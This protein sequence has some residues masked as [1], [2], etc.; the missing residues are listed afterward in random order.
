[1]DRFEEIDAFVRII[2]SGG[3]SAAAARTGAAKSKLSRRLADLEARLGVQLV[4][5]TTRSWT[6]TD[7]GR[8]FYQRAVRLLSDLREAE[9]SATA[10]QAA[11]S[12]RLRIAAPLSFGVAHMGPMLTKFA[13]DHPKV[14]LDIEFNDRPTDLVEEGFD[15]AIRI[16]RLASSSLVARKLCNITVIA[17]GAP[18]FWERF[19][20]P[21]TAEEL[22][23]L[24][25]LRYANAPPVLRAAPPEAQDRAV[26][27]A[28]NGDF[29]TR[30]CV[31]GLGFLIAPTFLVHREIESGALEPVL[32]DHKWSDL[33][34][35][36]LYPPA[37]HVSARLRAFIDTAAESFS[38]RPYWDECLR[39]NRA[40]S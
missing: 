17:S 12:G 15:A 37:R 28:N 25:Q 38:T 20:R 13:A 9:A 2:D 4:K 10:S 40:R 34:L 32:L 22:A 29:L 26:I 33:G 6:L 35:Y 3:V 8:D 23:Q 39:K 16:G 21:G 18:A 19:G 27:S 24:P 7:T 1:M 31:A 36:A 30:A 5:R 11:L 14:A